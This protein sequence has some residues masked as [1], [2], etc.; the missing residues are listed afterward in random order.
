MAQEIG[1]G[2]RLSRAHGG[3]KFKV[4]AS[5]AGLRNLRLRAED[6]RRFIPQWPA[7]WQSLLRTADELEA[8]MK[9]RK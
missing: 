2:R 8:T 7:L 5:R 6:Y 4:T 3:M 9:D 1:D